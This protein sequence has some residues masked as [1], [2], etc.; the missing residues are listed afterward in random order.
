MAFMININPKKIM[1]F[2]IWLLLFMIYLTSCCARKAGKTIEEKK[3]IVDFSINIPI[4]T[5]YLSHLKPRILIKIDSA[6]KDVPL[7]NKQREAVSNVVYREIKYEV[8]KQ[9]VIDTTI[10]LLD[11]T[12]VKQGSVHFKSNHK[13]KIEVDG[14]IVSRTKYLKYP[15]INYIY[16]LFGIKKIWHKVLFWLTLVVLFL[17]SVFG[18]LRKWIKI[19]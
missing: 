3:P 9:I 14:Y 15:F 19:L 10:A 7:T 5:S 17:I 11:S 12:G 4:D 16:D 2:V 1:V 13:G 8:P 18:Y 6:T